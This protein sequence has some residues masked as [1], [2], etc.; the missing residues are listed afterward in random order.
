MMNNNDMTYPSLMISSTNK[1]KINEFKRFF[2]DLPLEVKTPPSLL[3]INED[4]KTFVEN[5]RIKAIETA[6]LTNTFCLAD[7]S[8]LCIEALGGLPGVGS[9]RYAKSDAERVDRVLEEMSGHKNRNAYFIAAICISSPSGG[10]FLEVEAQCE[11]LIAFSARGLNGFGYDPIF[12]V[13]QTGLTF[14]EMDIEQKRKFGH[15]GKAFELLKP[16]I[17]EKISSFY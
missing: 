11:G 10:V 9:A 17:K 13:A 5:A 2:Y 15:R 16:L 6:K 3:K 12:E 1:G 4:G 14:A 7:D 8:G